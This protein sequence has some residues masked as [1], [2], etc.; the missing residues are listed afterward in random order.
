MAEVHQLTAL[1]DQLSD[2]IAFVRLDDGGDTCLVHQ[3]E[4]SS[5]EGWVE[6]STSDEAIFTTSRSCALVLRVKTCDRRELT[7]ARVHIFSI[8]TQDS[9]DTVQLGEGDLGL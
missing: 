8:S 1:L 2:V 5:S 4:D 3:V 9:L 6:I 7:L